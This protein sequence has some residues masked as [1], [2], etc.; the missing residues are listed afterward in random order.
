MVRLIIDLDNGCL[1]F[2]R[3]NAQGER[4]ARLRSAAATQLKENNARH[5]GFILHGAARLLPVKDRREHVQAPQPEVKPQAAA[6]ESATSKQLL[7]AKVRQMPGARALEIALNHGFVEQP[8][9]NN[10]VRF[11]R[12]KNHLYV[13]IRHGKTVEGI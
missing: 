10:G 7:E 9:P 2:V 3:D 12:A 11:M 13:L 6:V 1:D 8:A 4:R 5:E